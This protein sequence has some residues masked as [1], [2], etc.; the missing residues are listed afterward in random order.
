M[1]G[2]FARDP[3]SPRAA[4]PGGRGPRRVG[5]GGPPG[6]ESSAGE[7]SRRRVPAVPGRHGLRPRQGRPRPR[8]E[9]LRRFSARQEQLSRVPASRP[10][11]GPF[12]RP[13]GR[14][15]PVA[16]REASRSLLFV[17]PFLDGSHAAFARGWRRHSRHRWRIVSLP[18]AHWKWRLRTGAFELARRLAAEP[19][20]DAVICT[21][22]V[23]AAHLKLFAGPAGRVPWLVYWHENQF[24]YPRPPGQPLER[25]FAVAHLASVLAADGH[26]FNSRAHLEAMRAGLAA[27]VKEAAPPRPR[28]VLRHFD[29]AARVLP[30]GVELSGFPPPEPRPVGDPPAILWNHRWEEDKRPGAFARTMLRLAEGGASFRLILLGTTVQS[31]PRPLELL[32]E[33]LGDRILRAE[34]ARTRGSYL[35]WLR[36]ADLSVSTA[37]QEN[38]GYAT[39]EAMAAGVVPLLPERLSYPELVGRALAPHLLYRDERELLA[40]L[41]ALLENPQ[42]VAALRPAVAARA[43]IHSW[44]RRVVA[45][46]D[47]VAGATGRGSPE[48][49]GRAGGGIGARRGAGR[50]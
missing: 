17:E 1:V 28:G 21:S 30:P 20:P 38:F 44:E 27:F 4:C 13:R 41:R 45:L 14:L 50:R 2:G 43:R 36:R 23:D 15:P 29:R 16:E 22:L 6:A 24:S 8:R 47:W 42:R 10:G 5:R 46:D 31:R 48:G 7:A 3:P 11:R 35:A 25:S 34:P 26:G 33:K 32:R 12:R 9:P 19:A 37:A 49:F 18:G 39:V 40:R